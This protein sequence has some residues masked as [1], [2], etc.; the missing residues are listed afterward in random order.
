MKP[1]DLV[2]ETILQIVLEYYLQ[3]QIGHLLFAQDCSAC[4][5]LNITLLRLQ[6]QLMAN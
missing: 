2:N 3:R 5:A 1:L 4:F 6:M